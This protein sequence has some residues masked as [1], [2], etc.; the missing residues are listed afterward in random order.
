MECAL[1]QGVFVSSTWNNNKSFICFI[2]MLL[3][4]TYAVQILISNNKRTYAIKP[5]KIYTNCAFLAFL[6]LVVLSTQNCGNI[7]V[8]NN[9]MT[10]NFAEK[11]SPFYRGRKLLVA[12]CMYAFNCNDACNPIYN[13][14]CTTRHNYILYH[15]H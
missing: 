15:L 10:K 6:L 9:C 3:S 8:K 13:S 14:Q 12:R 1:T 7:T 11:R 4:S 5:Y 2:L